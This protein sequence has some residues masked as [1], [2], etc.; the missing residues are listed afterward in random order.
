MRN[1]SA[2]SQSLPFLK[3]INHN[4]MLYAIC[5]EREEVIGSSQTSKTWISSTTFCFLTLCP[6]IDMQFSLLENLICTLFL[7][8][9]RENRAPKEFD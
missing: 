2:V 6:F 9:C 7:L 1:F 3:E 5:L 4:D 8:C